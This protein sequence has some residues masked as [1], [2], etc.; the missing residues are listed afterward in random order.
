MIRLAKLREIPEILNI[1]KACGEEML[2]RGIA[3]WNDHYPSEK[4]FINDVKRKELFVLFKDSSLIG[5]VVLSKYMD[6]EY[7]A[8]K[9]LCPDE[10]N[11]YVHRLAIHPNFQSQGYARKLMD[12]AEEK[13][14]RD[15]AVS[16]RL[17]TFSQNQRNQRFYEQ[18]GYRR[19][20]SVYFPNQ[21]QHPFYCYELLL[22]PA[23]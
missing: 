23:H 12:F 13:A 1:T 15:G 14:R 17:D 4:A 6:E 11:R 21:S 9:W 19:L 5:S 7:K 10:N 16:I 20:G 2:S 18:R 8:V 22:K 3:Q